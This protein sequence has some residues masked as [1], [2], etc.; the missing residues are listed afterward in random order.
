MITVRA[1]KNA[2]LHKKAVFPML[3]RSPYFISVSDDFLFL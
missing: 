2:V 3:P 1:G